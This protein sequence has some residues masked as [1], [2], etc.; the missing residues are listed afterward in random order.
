MFRGIFRSEV[1]FEY[2]DVSTNPLW[3]SVKRFKKALTD[4]HKGLVDTSLY[5][6]NA[7]GEEYGENSIH[8]KNSQ[9][10]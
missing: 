6:E 5:S 8:K 9:V 7:N 2:N 3:Q 1:C 10:T 4:C